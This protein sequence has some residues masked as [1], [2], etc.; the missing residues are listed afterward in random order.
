MPS[1]ILAFDRQRNARQIAETITKNL[2]APVR[3][4]S[5][6]HEWQADYWSTR[7]SYILAAVVATRSLRFVALAP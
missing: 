3:E 2:D 7:P 1:T 5:D 6:S 4:R